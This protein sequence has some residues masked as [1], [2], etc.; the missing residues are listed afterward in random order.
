MLQS[1]FFTLSEFISSQTAKEHH[2][3]NMPTADIIVNIQYGCDMVLDPLRRKLSKSVQ[4]TSGYRCQQLNRLVGGVSNS[5]HMKGNAV[6]IHIESEDDAKVKFDILKT[7]PSVDTC[8][9]EHSK[10]T[11]WLHVQWDKT[12]APRHHFNYN[13]RAI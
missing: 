6:D 9:F 1:E 13:Y 8:L 10:L 12:K 3:N 11:K 5:W 4:I 7:L 2:I